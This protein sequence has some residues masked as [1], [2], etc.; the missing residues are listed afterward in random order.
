MESLEWVKTAS[1][2]AIVTKAELCQWL[3]MPAR[4]LLV[5]MM[6]DPSFPRPRFGNFR[7]DPKSKSGQKLP[8]S[9]RWRVGDIRAWLEGSARIAKEPSTPIAPN[10]VWHGTGWGSKRA[11]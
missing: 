9:C 5:V 3:A 11:Q 8:S 2:H 6:S 10:S 7:P 4:D 1:N